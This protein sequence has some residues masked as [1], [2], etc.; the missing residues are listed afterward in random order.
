MKEVQ[1]S[2]PDTFP[3]F[4]LQITEFKRVLEDTIVSGFKFFNLLLP[5]TS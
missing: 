1:E 2:Q 4:L 5:P 3:Y